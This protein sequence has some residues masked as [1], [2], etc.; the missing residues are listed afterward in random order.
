MNIEDAFYSVCENSKK[1]M[2]SCKWEN[3][4]FYGSWLAQQYFLVRHTTR[5]IC[6]YSLRVPLENQEDYKS[7]M[8]HLKEEGGHDQWILNDLNNLNLSI[9]NYKSL[10][11]T[12]ALIQSQYYQINY[13]PP[14]SFCGYSQFLE[15]L[16]VLVAGS[17]ADRVDRSFGK[18]A[19]VF[20]RGHSVV[21]QEHIVYGFK[22]LSKINSFEKEKVIENLEN[23]SELYNAMLLKINQPVARALVA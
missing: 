21:D 15:V 22:A 6:A 3:K 10:P 20:L 11:Q 14:V 16:A 9:G 12:S 17:L 23:C 7:T 13:E 18:K 19:S 1:I 2:I 4:D 5:L 8:H